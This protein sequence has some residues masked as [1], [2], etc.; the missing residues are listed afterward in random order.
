[1][2]VTHRNTHTTHLHT[3]TEMFLQYTQTLDCMCVPTDPPQKLIK[4]KKLTAKSDIFFL[5]M[6]SLKNLTSMFAAGRCSLTRRPLNCTGCPHF[7]PFRTLV[8]PASHKN[9]QNGYK[10]NCKPSHVHLDNV[11]V[12]SYNHNAS[13]HNLQKITKIKYNFCGMQIDFC[14]STHNY[15]M[16][17]FTY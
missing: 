14:A 5:I 17:F 7:S 13:S 1:M 12:I 10:Q 2:T 4:M 11:T 8:V 9:T 16:Y 6:Q 15:K 3:S